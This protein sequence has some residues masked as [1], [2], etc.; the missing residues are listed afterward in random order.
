MKRLDGDK[1]ADKCVYL[2]DQ[3]WD[4]LGKIKINK[5]QWVL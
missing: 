2:S 3:M 4:D 5:S 1:I